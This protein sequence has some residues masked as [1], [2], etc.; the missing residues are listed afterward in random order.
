MGMNT[1]RDSSLITQAV[2]QVANV[3]RGEFAALERAED[4]CPGGDADRL[5]VIEP[6]VYESKARG[7]QAHDLTRA[8]LSNSEIDGACLAVEITGLKLQCCPDSTAAA[9]Q[10]SDQRPVANPSRSA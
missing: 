8:V 10:Q 7:V 5:S 6:A 3:D 1:F 9:V 2:E 4:R